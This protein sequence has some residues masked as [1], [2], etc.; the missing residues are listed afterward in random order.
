METKKKIETHDPKYWVLCFLERI[1][2]IGNPT[3]MRKQV[4]VFLVARD[5]D[6]HRMKLLQSKYPG[7]YLM[8]YKASEINKFVIP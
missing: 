1:T 7:S 2:Q 3:S 8:E 5:P 6:K 4:G